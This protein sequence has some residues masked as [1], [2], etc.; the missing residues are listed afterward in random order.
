MLKNMEEYDK[1]FKG[2][3]G[4]CR[5]LWTDEKSWM[6]VRWYIKSGCMSNCKHAASHVPAN[7]VPNETKTDMMTFMRKMRSL[8]L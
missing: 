3:G 1:V 2:K 5:V 4:E 7:Q 8:T 6:C